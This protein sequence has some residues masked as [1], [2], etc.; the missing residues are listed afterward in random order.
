M[1]FAIFITLNQTNI[2]VPCCWGWEIYLPCSYHMRC[3]K[4]LDSWIYGFELFVQAEVLANASVEK[5]GRNL[6]IIGLEFKLKET[7]K[8]IYTARAS[9]YN[10]LPVAKLW[11]FKFSGSFFFSFFHRYWN[12]IWDLL[13]I[14]YRKLSQQTSR[15][16]NMDSINKEKLIH[17]RFTQFLVG[18]DFW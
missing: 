5:S 15:D 8:L 10:N 14:E 3:C 2:Y 6:T 13:D 17:F 1:L 12:I 16:S 4:C 7:G 9:L 11:T 18:I